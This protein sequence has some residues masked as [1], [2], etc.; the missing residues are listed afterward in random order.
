MI[1]VCNILLKLKLKNPDIK[2]QVED[3]IYKINISKDPDQY[4][5]GC[6]MSVVNVETNQRDIYDIRYDKTFKSSDPIT[7][8][9]DWAYSIWTGK[10]GSWKII[11]FSIEKID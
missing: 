8:I 6:H 2:Q 5:N 11:N 4:G 10:N 9:K 3:F 1:N 7:Y